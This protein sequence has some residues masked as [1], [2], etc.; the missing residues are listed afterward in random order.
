MPNQSDDTIPLSE[1]AARQ[2]A[3]YHRIQQEADDALQAEADYRRW[4]EDD[5]VDTDAHYVDAAQLLTFG[6]YLAD[7]RQLENKK[8]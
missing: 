8:E 4:F 5:A 1:A 7:K 6:K 2:R 3:I